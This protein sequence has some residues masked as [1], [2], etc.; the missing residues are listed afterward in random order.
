[1]GYYSNAS[2]TNLIDKPQFH[3]VAIKV[4]KGMGMKVTSEGHEIF[5][6]TIS[7]TSFAGEYT[8]HKVKDFLWWYNVLA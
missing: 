3:E 4:F 2:K 1:M 5:N 8:S 7:A 6:S